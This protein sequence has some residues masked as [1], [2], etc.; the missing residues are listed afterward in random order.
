MGGAGGLCHCVHFFGFEAGV[1]FAD[2]L[3]DEGGAAL[4]RAGFEGELGDGAVD[5]LL[6]LRLLKKDRRRKSIPMLL[7]FR[8]QVL[9]DGRGH[10]GL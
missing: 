10:G 4:A 6:S 9:S 1:F 2:G 7:G 3:N 5:A 8:G